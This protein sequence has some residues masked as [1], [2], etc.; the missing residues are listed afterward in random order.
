MIKKDR[1]GIRK[2]LAVFSAFIILSIFAYAASDDE[3]MPLESL[4]ATENERIN[5][6]QI[7]LKSHDAEAGNLTKLVLFGR[8]QTKHWQGYYGDITGTITLDDAQNWT[9]YDWDNPEPKGEIYA[10]ANT[11]GTTPSW[12]TVECFNYTQETAGAAWANGNTTLDR[13]ETY[14]NMT[15]NDVDGINETFNVTTHLGFSVGSYTIDADSCPA[16]YTYV[17]DAYQQD[18]FSEILLQTDEAQLVF[19]TII[20]NDD[21]ANNTDPTG[22]DDVAHDFQMLVAEDGTSLS[23]GEINEDPTTYYFYIDIE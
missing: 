19:A 21:E 4:N 18:K 11:S 17:S 6:S 9:L 14:Y 7:P 5:V 8:S 15:W 13:W 2:I 20:E 12:S 1:S 10:V 16:T 3:P 22:F 23:A